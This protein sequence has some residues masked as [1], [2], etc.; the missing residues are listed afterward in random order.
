[1]KLTTGGRMRA[2]VAPLAVAA[3]LLAGCGDGGGDEPAGLDAGESEPTQEAPDD[4]E[5]PDDASE[6]PTSPPPAEPTPTE[7]TFPDAG[8][9][10]AEPAAESQA[11][12]QALA[13]YTEFARHWRLSLREVRMSEKLSGLAVPSVLDVIEDSLSYQEEH[14]IRYSGRMHVTPTVEESAERVVILG[15]CIDASELTIIEDGE[16][17]PIDGVEE[18]PRMPMR[19]TVAN[20]GAGWRVNENTLYEDESC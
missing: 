17:R 3:V 12:D 11:V 7:R 2:V 10:V 20:D 5:A 14:E 4:T 6:A 1:M 16:E 19:V 13:T 9:T 8:L 15:G 18:H